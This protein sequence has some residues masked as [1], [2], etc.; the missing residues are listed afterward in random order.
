MASTSSEYSPRLTQEER[1]KLAEYDH[2]LD[3]QFSEEELAFLEENGYLVLRGI[4][5][6]PTID[7]LVQEALDAITRLAGVELGNP[8]SWSSI[9]FHGLFNIWHT[10]TYNE[11]RQ[12]PRLYSV[13]AQLLKTHALTVSVDRI[14]IKTPALTAA[15]SREMQQKNNFLDL[16]TDLNF[17]HADYTKP[18]YQGGLC[19]EDCP[20]GGGGF[21]CI[22][23]FHRPERVRE[24]MALVE[25]GK[26]GPLKSCIPNKS[27]VFVS[28]LDKSDAV[29]H[30]VEVPLNKGDFV[31][32]NN[33]LPHNGGFNS[34]MWPDDPTS[35]T[36]NFRLHAYIMFMPL[37]GPCAPDD[38]ASY[39]KGFQAE[40]RRSILNHERPEN[41]ATRHRTPNTTPELERLLQRTPH[42]ELTR[43]GEHLLGLTPWE[44]KEED[45]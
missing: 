18:L 41:F 6:Q 37:E 40:V 14:N 36:R 43:L 23:G 42:T 38:I 26:F 15:Q 17:W 8:S 35:P 22:P 16:H 7:T 27:R 5:D 33:N 32:W 9:P 10:K 30:K 1:G 2:T 45:E 19:L 12:N 29:Q 11:L 39:Y 31:I 44:F 24:Y 3:Y 4:I 28:Y 34:L 13:F 25:K 21:F 20:I